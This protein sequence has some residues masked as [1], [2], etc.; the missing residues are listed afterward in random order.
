MIKNILMIISI[1]APMSPNRIVNASAARGSV[2][3]IVYNLNVMRHCGKFI[4]NY[5]G[6]Y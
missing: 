2:G 5:C 1:F 4:E 3:N 6:N